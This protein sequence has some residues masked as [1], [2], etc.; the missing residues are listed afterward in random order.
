MSKNKT[1]PKSKSA[2]APK[3]PRSKKPRPK[4]EKIEI[5]IPEPDEVKTLLAE[6]PN[7]V[8]AKKSF[9]AKTKNWFKIS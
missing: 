2:S 9:W 6:T 4:I 7:E 1:A 8:Q 5:D 3:K